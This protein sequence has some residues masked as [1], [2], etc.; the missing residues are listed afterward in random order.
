M[1][2]VLFDLDG[3]VANTEILKAKALSYSILSMGGE[4]PPEIYKEVMGQSWQIVINRFF[5]YGKI[6][7]DT[8]SLN[9][10]FRTHYNELIQ[11]ELKE[12]NGISDFI[13]FLKTKSISTGLVS[14]ASSWMIQSVLKKLN[15]E[16]DFSVIISNSDTTNHKPHPE[17]YF[18]AL[19]NLQT[20]P[21]AAIAF[22]DSNAGF[23]AATSA[24]LDVFGVKHRFNQGHNFILCRKAI[25]SFVEC[26]DWKIF[27]I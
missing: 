20:K 11:K 7:P 3:T 16:N 8:E 14:S 9:S 26:K 12:E 1:K 10:L 22:E 13:N 24:G 5:E 19:D 18:I 23:Q 6:E 27:D 21:S 17:A 4:A 15:M 25:T 2:S